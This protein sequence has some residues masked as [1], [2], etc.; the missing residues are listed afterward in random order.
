MLNLPS[1]KNIVNQLSPNKEKII[2]KIEEYT[3]LK[4]VKPENYYIIHKNEK[5]IFWG[6]L[7]FDTLFI[8]ITTL[9]VTEILY[10]IKKK[11]K[12]EECEEYIFPTLEQSEQWI[13][14]E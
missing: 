1:I 10:V 5:Y 13:Y 9:D 12:I 14:L 6:M 4:D 3:N 8:F 2:K 11:L 7:I